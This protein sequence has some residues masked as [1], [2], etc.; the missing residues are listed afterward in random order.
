MAK[1]GKFEQPRTK[2][3]VKTRKKRPVLPILAG[4]LVLL[5]V[6]LLI[7]GNSLLKGKTIYPNVRVAGVEVGGM[8]ASAAQEKVEQVMADM[9]LSQTLEV[10]L[11]DRT[12]SFDPEQTNVVVDGQLAIAE[13]MDV[14]R[15]K[16]AFSAV[17]QYIKSKKQSQ[18]VELQTA[19]Q[20]DTVYLQTL[21]YQTAA[22]V[23][24]APVNS[25]MS[26]DADMT[27]VTVKVGR[28]GRELDTQGLYDAVYTAFQNGTLEPMVWDYKQ[29]PFEDVDLTA[30][31]E[32]LASR[33]KD[34]YYDEENRTIVPQVNG[35]TFDLE[36]ELEHL[37]TA[38]EGISFEIALEEL[39]PELTTG[40]L[41]NQMFGEKLEQ[42]S[43]VYVN[44]PKR[45]EN[46]RL[47]CE[48]I[49]G[50]I[51]NPG[52]V[53][54]FN[55]VVGERTEEKGYQP[56]T[57]YGGEGESV[58]G[59]GGGVCQVASTIYYAALYLDLPT[60]MRE[61]HMYVVTYV[62]A[63]CDA[64]IYWGSGLDYKFKNNRENPIKIQANIDDGKCNITFW[65][66]KENDNYVKL[67]DPVT[68]ETWTD[69]D[70]EVVDETK[71]VGFKEQKQTAY[72]GSKVVVTKTV[73]D[74]NGEVLREEKLY[75]TYK[76]RP[77]IY[78][79]GPSE[80]LPDEEIPEELP[81]EDFWEEDFY[82]GGL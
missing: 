80:E 12:L 35:H 79:V 43:S 4:I 8:T 29:V 2:T 77:N 57:I 66:I 34:A 19:L 25:S 36:A 31:H 50:T 62:P 60:V 54:S 63:G 1:K 73:Y 45:T 69:P 76:S 49:N 81:E 44:N 75:S 55:D 27:K 70:E 46:L 17:F 68:L 78:I 72:T 20:L 18:D 23:K 26:M 59:V 28:S 61:P 40:K 37:A 32:K 24:T 53:F 67:S 6:I 47:A 7:W 3:A 82:E 52:D 21:I 14:G 42:R 71:P 48:A 58:D 5:A 51:L 33:T 15:N 39:Q 16:G 10:H 9:Y 74:G 13:A 30:L 41:T 65:G 64:T 11:P 38:K 56:A 22:D